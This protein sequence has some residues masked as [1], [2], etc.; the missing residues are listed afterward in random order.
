[1]N[2]DQVKGVLQKIGGRIEE[3]AGTLVGDEG[4][5]IAGKEDQLK[6]GAREAWGNVKDAG[7]NLIDQARASK[8]DAELKS[9][10]ARAFDQE[11]EIKVEHE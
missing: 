7:N 3:A 4:L 9:E 11:H 5:K 2:G 8:A 10:R 1:M 6:G